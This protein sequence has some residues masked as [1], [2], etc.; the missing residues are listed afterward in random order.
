MQ[1]NIATYSQGDDGVYALN[2]SLKNSFRTAKELLAYLSLEP[3]NAP[4]TIS[5]QRPFTLL[6][7]REFAQRIR[8]KDWHDPLLRQVLPLHKE[9]ASS[10]A[11]M[12]LKSHDVVGDLPARVD[13]G[14][15]RKY[16]GRALIISHG[17]CAVHCRYCFRRHFPYTDNIVNEKQW[18]NIMASLSQDQQIREVILSGGDPLM[19]SD[20][21]ISKMLDD[22]ASLKSL[23]VIRLH[24]RVPIMC[25]ARVSNLLLQSFKRCAKKIVIVVHINHANEIDEETKTALR[26]L[27]E[28]SCL[29]NQS[30][31]LAG[32]NDE[33]QSLVDLSW[34]LFDCNTLPYYLHILDRVSGVEHFD[35]PAPAAKKLHQDIQAQLP[36][37]LVPRLVFEEAGA[38]HKIWL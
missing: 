19:H 30:V 10:T 4:E 6:V 29:L 16:T 38:A 22:L 3:E 11:T 1:A 37:Y 35:V 13:R 23:R 25:P 28:V 15:I 31:L 5:T 14:L 21:K 9:Y 36:G 17:G 32:V 24:T 20:Q 34:G 26:R 33:A 7:T 12:D 2:R 18:G 8:V 27:A